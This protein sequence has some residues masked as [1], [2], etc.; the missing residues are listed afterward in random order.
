MGVS[1]SAW[2]DLLDEEYLKSYV[3]SGGAAV[4]FALVGNEAATSELVT[5]VKQRGDARGYL[6]AEVDA[7]ATRVHMTQDLFFA[8]ARQIPWNELVRTFLSSTYREL[9]YAID[10]GELQIESVAGHNGIEPMVL[11][12][13]LSKTLQAKLIRRADALAKDF[14]WAMFGLCAGE[15]ELIPDVGTWAIEGWLKGE[16]RLIGG[17]KPFQIFRKIAR[18]NASAM[19]ASLG[20]W[21]RMAGA[22]GLVVTIDI[23]QL[24]IAKRTDAAPE[25][26]FYTSASLMQCYE[27]LRQL[28]DETE[29]LTGIL[30]LVVTDA[31]FLNVDHKRGVTRYWALHERIWPDV[32]IRDT[33]NPLSALVSIDP[34][35][36]AE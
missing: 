30:C 11:R 2:I 9:G 22:A 20:A 13:E 21:C 1:L 19:L 12:A 26:V 3:T 6:F 8:F 35:G 31:T 16:L 33:P 18:H 15:S 5:R 17:L 28:I 34:S 25:S 32:R 29:A 27:V 4:K 7:A 10:N 24:A 36:E 14:R 23:R